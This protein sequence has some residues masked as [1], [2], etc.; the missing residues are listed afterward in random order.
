MNATL[1]VDLIKGGGPAWPRLENDSHL[2]VVGSGR[3]LDAAW[4]A[5]HVDMVRWLSQLY[6]LETLDAY[7]LLSQIAESPLA[8]VVDPNF[9]ALAKV[10]RRVLPEAPA[11]GGIHAALRDQA[12]AL[13]PITY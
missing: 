9:S 3:P 1:I 6:Q 5:A 10:D 11:Y 7:Q 13:G 4:K 12:E 2:M 8:N